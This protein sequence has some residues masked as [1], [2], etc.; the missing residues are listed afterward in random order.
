MQNR[1]RQMQAA[2]LTVFTIIMMFSCAIAGDEYPG[3]RPGDNV[4]TDQ[5]WIKIHSTYAP[6]QM[7]MYD[8]ILVTGIE[9]LDAVA[10]IFGVYKIE[11]AHILTEKDFNNPKADDLDRWY[12]VLFPEDF[13]LFKVKDAYDRC[14]ELEYSEFVSR[15]KLIYIPNDPRYRIQWH[16]HKCGFE[17]AWDVS[18]G[19]ENI[20]IGIVDSG[21]DMDIHG[22]DSM[23]I[24]EDLIDNLW[25]NLG[26]DANGDGVYSDIDD[27]DGIDND[28]NGYADDFYGWDFES[29]NNWP[30]DGWR[31]EDGGGHGTHV[32]GLAS[33][34][35]DNEIG[36]SGAGFNCKLMIAACYNNRDPD[37]MSPN[38]WRGVQYCASNGAHV[39][40]LSW[41]SLSQRGNIRNTDAIEF[42]Q[43]EGSIIFAGAGNDDVAD[44]A[45]GREHFFPCATPDVIGVGATTSGDNKADFS[46]WGDYT[47]IVAPGVDM[48]ST[49]PHNTYLG[50]QGTSM[51]SP[52]AC[53][54]GALLLSVTPDLTGPQLQRR[55][56]E[57][58]VD[59]QER[60]DDYPGIQ[61]RI[62]AD[63]LLNSTHPDFEIS[64]W[65]FD[66]IEGNGDD[67][68]EPGEIFSMPITIS[69]TEGYT[70]AT[71]VTYSIRTDD[72]RVRFSNRSGTLGDIRAG[73]R[74]EIPDD[75]APV[76]SLSWSHPHF[77]TFELSVTSD[78][79]WSKEFEI[80]VTIGHPYYA[81]IDDDGGEDIEK[82][83]IE[84]LGNRP[85]IYSHYDMVAEDWWPDQ[86]WVNSFPVVIW[87]TG[88]DRDALAD[89]EILIM[90]DYLDNGG[91]LILSGQYLGDDHGDSEFFS[92]YLHA[93]HLGNANSR[94]PKGIEGNE[95][96]NDMRFLLLGGT[97]AANSRF[98][99]IIEPL[100]GAQPLFTY[101]DSE[102]IA[103]TMYEE[104]GENGYKAIY[105]GFA[106]EAAA[107]LGGTS[108]RYE[109]INNA[110]DYMLT[111]GVNDTPERPLPQTFNLSQPWPNPFNST[112]EVRVRIPETGD[113]SLDVVDVRG[114]SIANLYEG[115][116]APGYA[117]FVWDAANSPAGE[118]FFRLTHDE[119]FAVRKMVLVK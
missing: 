5:L 82:Y 104:E 50:I 46:N 86:E 44:F 42:A 101:G 81:I 4:F 105:I 11:K 21:A 72:I 57:T 30:N 109:F 65:E 51:S 8:N 61:Y 54:T 60:N 107:G 33:A 71:N 108:F 28:D 2:F 83:F 12:R 24:H 117:N 116:H 7:D 25:F 103:G 19:D 10:D 77:S 96:T 41:G 6:L 74:L 113:F 76:F 97:A 3:V 70:D 53:G 58:A 49:W 89:E 15:D 100:E 98:P 91:N 31:A 118:Y 47:D 92:N 52:F 94:E 29:N 110:L 67:M 9:S 17:K 62:D 16:L 119:G 43:A 56:Q 78:E 32:A 20:I 68:P 88:N 111:V 26:E 73:D 115:S 38:S 39:I 63:K 93:G 69:N 106:L 1:S 27:W 75:E 35:T 23:I 18:H 85:F 99:S 45:N 59:I 48:W 14:M 102:D 80:P 36:V 90:E 55:M 40:N 22:D 66:E 34:T 37:V 79:G 87:I 64:R 13:D 95:L 114:R 84:D 112:T